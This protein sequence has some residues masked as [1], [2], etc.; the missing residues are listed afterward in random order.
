[1]LTLLTLAL[2]DPTAASSSA[3]TGRDPVV[4]SAPREDTQRCEIGRASWF[5]SLP[6]AVGGWVGGGALKGL[7]PLPPA[8]CYKERI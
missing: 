4:V 2:S 8:T 5:L 6:P 1:M 3:I 7:R